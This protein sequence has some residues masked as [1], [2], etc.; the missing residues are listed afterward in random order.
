MVACETALGRRAAVPLFG[1]DYPTADGTCI[2]DFVHVSD[3]AEAH[4][5]SL[6]YLLS[7]GASR[8]FNCGCGRGYSVREVLDAVGR[9][10]GR[11]FA[12]Q[13]SPRRPGDAVELVAATER[14]RQELGWRPS[15]GHLDRMVRDTLAL[16]RRTSI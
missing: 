2:R 8:T 3:L 1:D 4:L 12:V 13:R 10:S 5:K 7:G 14:I 15:G 9:I 11:M 6:E 16:Q